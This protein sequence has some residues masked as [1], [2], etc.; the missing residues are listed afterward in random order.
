MVLMP[1]LRYG[2]NSYSQLTVINEHIGGIKPFTPIYMTKPSGFPVYW[3]PNPTHKQLWSNVQMGATCFQ[4]QPSYDSGGSRKTPLSEVSPG[5]FP[6]GEFFCSIWG[7]GV[8]REGICFEGN[9]PRGNLFWENF[10]VTGNGL[11]WNPWILSIPS[12]PSVWVFMKFREE[13]NRRKY[14]SFIILLTEFDKN[15]KIYIYIY[16]Y[17]YVYILKLIELNCLAML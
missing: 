7:G 10:P 8:F 3:G 13:N 14:F 5:N 15:S 17:T 1:H 2:S 11:Y 6:E 12:I 9:F 4:F 16:T